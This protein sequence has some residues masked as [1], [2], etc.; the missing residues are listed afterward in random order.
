MHVDTTVPSW[1]CQSTVPV[2]ASSAY[3]DPACVE[4]LR[5]AVPGALT[6]YGN[7]K[8]LAAFRQKAKGKS[9]PR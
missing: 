4:A 6:T 7:M 8:L 1:R 9:E 3:T 2:T 5:A